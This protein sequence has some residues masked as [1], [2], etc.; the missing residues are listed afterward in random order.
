VSSLLR[1]TKIKNTINIHDLIEFMSVKNNTMIP[2]KF[3]PSIINA[4][5]KNYVI[6]KEDSK[7]YFYIEVSSFLSLRIQK[8]NTMLNSLKSEIRQSEI[9]LGKI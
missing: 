7:V 4:G 8:I 1:P 2:Q 5:I 3:I 9:H 6:E